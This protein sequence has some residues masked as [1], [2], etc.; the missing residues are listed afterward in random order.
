MVH[1]EAGKPLYFRFY[2]P[3]VLRTYLPTCNASELAQIFGPVECYVQEGED[4]G[5]LLRFRQAGGKL[6]A[7]KE[8]LKA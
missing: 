2:D 8:A 6:V 7:G 3:R 5:V 1:D 4:P